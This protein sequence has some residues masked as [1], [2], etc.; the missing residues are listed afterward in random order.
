[1]DRALPYFQRLGRTLFAPSVDP[2][3]RLGELFERETVEF[4]MEY[5]FLSQIDRESE[6]QRYKIVHGAHEILNSTT[7]VPLSKTYCRETIAHPEGTLA[8]SDAPAEGWRND[9]AY[10]LFGFGSYLGTTV[11]VAGKTYGTLCFADSTVRGEPFTENEKALVDMYGQ[12][13]GY[14]LSY[15]DES[16]TRE[17]CIDTIEGRAVSSD[18]IDSMMDVLSTH[19]RRVIL[20]ALLGDTTETSITTLERGPHRN[21]NRIQLY[22]KHLPKLAESGYIN[23]DDDADTISKGPKFSEVEPLVQLLNE[24]EAEFPA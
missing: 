7:T 18:G 6:S 21:I 10:E 13:V 1:M 5:A 19:T 14:M 4:D 12:W 3:T 9:P 16:L 11:S 24:Y 17:A 20:M 8:V 23:W 15:C 2:N 22:H